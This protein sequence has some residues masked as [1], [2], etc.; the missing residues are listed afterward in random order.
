MKGF[1]VM[2]PPNF[3]RGEVLSNRGDDSRTKFEGGE[4]PSRSQLGSRSCSETLSPN[5][6][7]SQRGCEGRLQG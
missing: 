7:P 4:I 6:E 2:N 5:R 3:P 1:R